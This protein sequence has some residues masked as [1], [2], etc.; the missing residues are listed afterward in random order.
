MTK[1]TQESVVVYW[2]GEI[3]TAVVVANGAHTFYR[4]RK[5]NRDDVAN[6]LGADKQDEN[7]R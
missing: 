1:V 6:L 5:L 4:L 7:E 3:P 2:E